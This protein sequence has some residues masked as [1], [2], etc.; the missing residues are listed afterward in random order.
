MCWGHFH[1]DVQEVSVHAEE[2][3][4][5][6]ACALARNAR[7]LGKFDVYARPLLHQRR[8]QGRRSAK[9]KAQE[10]QYVYADNGGAGRG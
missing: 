7:G 4:R 2:Q 3:N 5:T 8:E 10:P 1:G 9:Q 6:D